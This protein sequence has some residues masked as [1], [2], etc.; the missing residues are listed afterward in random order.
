MPDTLEL[1]TSIWGERSIRAQFNKAWIY[2]EK[3]LKRLTTD[4]LANFDFFP[5]KPGISG[6]RTQ[7]PGAKKTSIPK[8]GIVRKTTKR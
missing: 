1:V 4:Y 6:S 2:F 3:F 7:N 8:S 5:L